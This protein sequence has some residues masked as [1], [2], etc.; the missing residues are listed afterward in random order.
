MADEGSG[1]EGGEGTGSEG[2]GTESWRDGFD[3]H[4]ALA[5]F[6]DSKE[7]AFDVVTKSFLE[8]KELVGRRGVILPKEDDAADQA[9][10]FNELGRPETAG[11]YELNGFAP[12]EGVPWD[13]D[14]QGE[15]LEMF[16]G[17]G[18]TNA[19]TAAVMG[20]YGGALE[21]GHTGMQDAMGRAR[22]EAVTQLKSEL[23]TAYEPQM[24]L[25][26]QAFRSAAG[27]QYD[28]VDAL[29]LADGTKLNDHPAFI[30]TF[31]NIGKQ[32]A[33]HGTHGDKFQDTTLKTPET[34]LADIKALEQEPGL[35][36]ANHPEHAALMNKKADLYKMAYPEKGEGT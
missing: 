4:P 13:E 26:H 7:E 8:T 29:I 33:E 15:A 22:T 31:I 30:Q 28:A 20:W 25:A 32:Y 21:K 24:K 34:A 23:G 36:D 16:H 2:G 1:N 14:L 5:S 17:I 9:R 11:G 3:N 19:Q 10:F 12:P 18:L 6:P 27:D 35:Y